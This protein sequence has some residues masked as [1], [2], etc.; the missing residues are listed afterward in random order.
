MNSDNPNYQMVDVNDLVIDPSNP[1]VISDLDLA[2]L[3]SSLREFGFV[4]P[5]VAR[6][7]D[8]LIIGGHQRLQAARQ[9]GWREVPVLWWEG[10]DRQAR[11]LALALNKIQGDWD[12]SKL[13]TVLGELA[14][15]DSL[16]E[17]LLGFDTSWTDLAGFDP[18]EVLRLL[19]AELPADLVDVE[20]F[21]E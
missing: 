8:R 20:R 18:K 5:I 1:R 14:E 3:R 21:L 6:K 13:A 10:D 12:E 11:T 16:T 2:N 7:S 19:D 4:Q 17:A 15:V 9:E